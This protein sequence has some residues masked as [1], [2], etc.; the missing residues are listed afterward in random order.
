MSA[1]AATS[2]WR[3]AAA[4][5]GVGIPA[6]GRKASTGGASASTSSLAAQSTPTSPTDTGL[7]FTRGASLRAINAAASSSGTAAGVHVAALYPAGTTGG[8]AQGLFLTYSRSL[9]ATGP[10]ATRVRVLTSAHVEAVGGAAAA[11]ATPGAGALEFVSPVAGSEEYYAHE[12]EVTAPSSD[13]PSRGQRLSHFWG[14]AAV[15]PGPGAGAVVFA[16]ADPSGPTATVPGGP[17]AG[18]V[19]V[20]VG[21]QGLQGRRFLSAGA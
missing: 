1:S 5:L 9:G 17:M 10:E 4:W 19:G 14:H 6:A 21:P 20:M 7:G 15:R 13:R 11:A 8:G 18:D 3:A 12:F 16:S 2:C